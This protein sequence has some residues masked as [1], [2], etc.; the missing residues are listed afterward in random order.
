MRDSKILIGL[1]I[2]LGNTYDQHKGKNFTVLYNTHYSD[3]KNKI[4]NNSYLW[5]ITQGN[6][7]GFSVN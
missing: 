2:T 1:L 7:L 5:S 4:K 6:I 3:L